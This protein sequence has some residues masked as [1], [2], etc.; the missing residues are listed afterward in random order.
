MSTFCF[1]NAKTGEIFDEIFTSYEDVPESISVKGVK[2]KRCLAAE[3][4]AQNGSPTS[5]WPRR[6]YAMA[7]P[8][9]KAKEFTERSAE[10]GVPTEHDN[11]GRPILTSELHQKKYGEIR[12]MTD[13]ESGYT[14]A[15]SDGKETLLKF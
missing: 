5:G 3:I 1:K 11:M 15:N 7:V 13:F 14:G 2:C 9:W 4:S 8:A 12:G 6:S 10:L